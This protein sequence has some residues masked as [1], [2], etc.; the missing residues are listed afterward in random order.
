[1]W[2][3]GW[4]AG[5]PVVILVFVPVFIVSGFPVS[6]TPSPRSCSRVL[7]SVF[8]SEIFVLSSVSG[9]SLSSAGM[10]TDSE[11]HV[12]VNRTNV[13][14]VP[15]PTNPSESVFVEKPT[16]LRIGPLQSAENPSTTDSHFHTIAIKSYGPLAL[17]LN[18]QPG[19]MNQTRDL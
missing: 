14:F 12:R 3:F 13:E 5:Y 7:T 15:T 10:G 6:N 2:P 4:E 9:R 11:F 17:V 18:P 16:I 8:G 1:M 19:S